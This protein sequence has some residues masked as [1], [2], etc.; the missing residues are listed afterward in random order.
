MP[1]K[2]KWDIPDMPAAMVP[3]R[4]KVGARCKDFG[5]IDYGIIDN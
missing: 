3:Q 5:D 1:K 2:C 4:D